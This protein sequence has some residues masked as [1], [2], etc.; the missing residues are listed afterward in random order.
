MWFSGLVAASCSGGAPTD[1]ARS[2]LK[3]SASAPAATTIRYT[4]PVNVD[5]RDVPLL[6]ALDD[7]ESRG[8]RVERNQVAGPPLIADMLAR[9]Q[10]DIGVLNNQ[11]MWSAVAKG[12]AV[13]TIMQFAGP[14]TVLAAQRSIQ[15]CTELDGKRMGVSG[16]AGLSQVLIQIYL[17]RRCSNA[18]PQLIVMAESSARSTALLAGRL[19]AAV[20]PGEELIKLQL[21]AP[22][23]LHA[24]MTHAAEYSN[25][26]IDGFQIRRAWA[27]AHPESV[28]DFLRAVLIAQRRVADDP[29]LLYAE[30]QKRLGIDEQTARAIGGSHLR[31][32]IWNPD[33]GLTAADI[34]YTIDFLVKAEALPAGLTVAQV[35]N[36]SYLD[37]V[38]GEI[39]RVTGPANTARAP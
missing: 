11:T 6:M 19:D 4:D 27:E 24:L 20:M 35:S 38:L 16:P 25:L 1:L 23:R 12:A 31:A 8:Y 34:Q 30:A 2:E 28:R 39:G 37:D 13:W 29:D 7:L 22:G 3:D 15:S 14:T 5:V 21:Q 26:P 18:V 17:R 10:T 33:G 9:G 36:L 32:G